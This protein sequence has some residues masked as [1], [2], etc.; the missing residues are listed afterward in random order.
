MRRLFTATALLGVLIPAIY[1]Q[2][3]PNALTPQ[4][5]KEGW[6]LLF[7]GKTMNGWEV[8]GANNWSVKDGALACPADAKSWLGTAD[9]YSD[10]R[11][12]LE[13]RASEKANSGVFLRSGKDDQPAVSGYE[14]QIWDYRE[15]Y[16]TGSLV[17]ALETTAPTR[18]APDQWNQYDITAQGDHFIVVHNTKTVLDG[19][20]SKHA[21]GVLGLQ[22]NA[23]HNPMEFRSI[24]VLVLKK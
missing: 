14:L 13:F 8:H 5:A 2:S 15:T 18:I 10:F 20:D 12:R 3:Q 23:D 21:S 1:A 9:S 11:L 22:C 17:N 6:K 7:D 24:K 16:K 19:R 4:E